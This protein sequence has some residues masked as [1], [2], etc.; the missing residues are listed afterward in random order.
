[1]ENENGY[2]KLARVFIVR[3]YCGKDR[4]TLTLFT[5]IR[6]NPHGVPVMRLCSNFTSNYK[7]PPITEWRGTPDRSS[8]PLILTGETHSTWRKTCPSATLS[9]INLIWSSLGSMFMLHPYMSY[10]RHLS[11]RFPHQ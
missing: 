7:G 2:L 9:T 8:T 5:V 6:Y 3:V 4:K 10:N 11:S 1:M